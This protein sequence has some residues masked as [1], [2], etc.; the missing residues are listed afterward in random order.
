MN[1]NQIIF[2]NEIDT[3]IRLLEGKPL[4][5]IETNKFILNLISEGYL[6]KRDN[7]NSKD[8]LINLINFSD[9][10]N[11]YKIVNQLEIWDT[12]KNPAVYFILMDCL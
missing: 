12:K 10:K 7:K 11:N 8:F 6:L 1:I 4:R 3:T 2:Q 9:P 5:F